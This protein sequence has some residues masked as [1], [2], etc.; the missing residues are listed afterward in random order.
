MA[1]SLRVLVPAAELPGSAFGSRAQGTSKPAVV[2]EKGSSP[3][4]TDVA[5]SAALAVLDVVMP[6]LPVATLRS[7]GPKIVLEAAG[8]VYQALARLGVEESHATE[9]SR[10]IT[11]EGARWEPDGRGTV[12]RRREWTRR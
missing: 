3:S 11:A 9:A 10:R 12:I 6:R 7:S 1:R 5:V 8:A 2:K 4:A